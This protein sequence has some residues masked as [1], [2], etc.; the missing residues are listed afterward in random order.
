[1]AFESI[2]G[3]N[4]IKNFFINVLKKNTLHH[5]YLFYGYEGIGIEWFAIELAKILLCKNRQGIEACNSCSSCKKMNDLTHPDIHFIFPIVRDSKNYKQTSADFINEWRN[6]ILKNKFF[7]LEDWFNELKIENQQMSIFTNEASNIIKIINSKPFESSNKVVFIYLPEKMHIFTANKLLKSIE[8]P[9]LNT[10]FLLITYDYESV[11]TTIKSRCQ[12]VKFNR[13]NDNDLLNY[14]NT[15]YPDIPNE[16]KDKLVSQSDGSIRN[17]ETFIN[18]N[19]IENFEEDNELVLKIF[20]LSYSRNF[21]EINEFCEILSSLGRERFKYLIL[22]AL[23]IIN[24]SF[25]LNNNVIKLVVNDK[26][27]DFINKFRVFLKN[28]DVQ[29]FYNN[30]KNAYYEISRNINI[31]LVIY[32]L[33][34]NNSLIFKKS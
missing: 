34:L 2:P 19:L 7:H 5:A 13:L 26:E 6:F 21:R 9:P 25:N 32:S 29:L 18:L 10:L 30:F 27:M 16:I 17:L 31:K 11:L 3:N 4:K 33:I 1:M 24:Y 20:R 23:N 14:L 28:Y 15:K 8:E 22:R 12:L